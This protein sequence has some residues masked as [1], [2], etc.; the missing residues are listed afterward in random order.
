MGRIGDDTVFVRNHPSGM[1]ALTPDI[2]VLF[3]GTTEEQRQLA[4]EKTR[5]VNGRVFELVEVSQ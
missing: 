2:M 3:P 1:R 4:F 5:P